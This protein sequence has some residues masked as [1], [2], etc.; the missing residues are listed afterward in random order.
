VVEFWS[1]SRSQHV[2]RWIRN[3]LNDQWTQHTSRSSTSLQRKPRVLPGAHTRPELPSETTMIRDHP[4][5]MLYSGEAVL[6]VSNSQTKTL[7][8]TVVSTLITVSSRILVIR[9]FS[10]TTR[11]SPRSTCYNFT[12]AMRDVMNSSRYLC[13]TISTINQRDLDGYEKITTYKSCSYCNTQFPEYV[14]IYVFWFCDQIF[15]FSSSTCYY[16]VFI[17]VIVLYWIGFLDSKSVQ[18]WTG[19]PIQHTVWFDLSNNLIWPISVS[20]TIF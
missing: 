13:V 19:D 11:S 5:R 18:V 2:P 15:L 1:S 7:H 17:Y 14:L 4:P 3:I 16:F 9:G 8:G 10:H 6:L 20:E 12:T